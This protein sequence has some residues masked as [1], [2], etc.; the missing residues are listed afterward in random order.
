MKNIVKNKL[1]GTYSSYVFK[2]NIYLEIDILRNTFI[3]ERAEF[4]FDFEFT[5]EVGNRTF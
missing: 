1:I 2:Y 5:I 3:K 4:D